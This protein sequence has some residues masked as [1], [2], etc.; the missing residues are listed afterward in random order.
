QKC[1]DVAAN[2]GAAI[3]EKRQAIVDI[4]DE[5]RRSGVKIKNDAIPEGKTLKMRFS[6]ISSDKIDAAVG[7]VRTHDV[8]TVGIRG[9]G[10]K[11]YDITN[12]KLKGILVAFGMGGDSRFFSSYLKSD[13]E[14]FLDIPTLEGKDNSLRRLC[15]ALVEYRIAFDNPSKEQQDID[16]DKLLH[17]A[18]CAYAARIDL[19]LTEAAAKILADNPD[20][21]ND[22]VTAYNANRPTSVNEILRSGTGW[23]SQVTDIV[24]LAMHTV[25]TNRDNGY[26]DASDLSYVASILKK[27]ILLI[28]ADGS[29]L[30]DNGSLEY[31]NGEISGCTLYAPNS[32]P[33]AYTISSTDK[34]RLKNLD[35]IIVIAKGAIHFCGEK[36][37]AQQ[38][39]HTETN[40]NEE[41]KSVDQ[42]VN[43]PIKDQI[44]KNDHKS[45]VRTRSKDKMP[46]LKESLSKIKNSFAFIFEEKSADQIFPEL[47]DRLDEFQN[48][49]LPYLDN[50]KKKWQAD[51]ERENLIHI[52]NCGGYMLK[53]MQFKPKF[54]A[55][56]MLERLNIAMF[57]YGNDE[58]ISVPNEYYKPSCMWDFGEHRAIVTLDENEKGSYAKDGRAQSPG[59]EHGHMANFTGV[60]VHE[61]SG[62][63]VRGNAFS[64]LRDHE[65]EYGGKAEK[66]ENY[67]LMPDGNKASN[68]PERFRRYLLAKA[69]ILHSDDRKIANM[70]GKFSSIFKPLVA[71]Y[72]SGVSLENVVSCAEN[73][74]KKSVNFENFD[75][76]TQLIDL[77]PIVMFIVGMQF[78]QIKGGSW[79]PFVLAA[80]KYFAL[81][82]TK[83]LDKY[84][85]KA[86]TKPSESAKELLSNSFADLIGLINAG[87]Y[88]E[89]IAKQF[90]MA[91][92]AY[93]AIN[94]EILS[95]V[96]FPGN[97]QNTRRIESIFR[98]ESPDALKIM[99]V[100]SKDA[101]DNAK[102]QSASIISCSAA[103]PVRSLDK[104]PKNWAQLIRIITHYDNVHHANVFGNHIFN[105]DFADSSRQ[106]SLRLIVPE[107]QVIKEENVVLKY[108][109]G[110]PFFKDS[111]R[112]LLLLT[113]IQNPTIVGILAFSGTPD[114]CYILSTKK[115]EHANSKAN[116]LLNL[117]D[118]DHKDIEN[119]AKGKGKRKMGISDAEKK[120]MPRE[121]AVRFCLGEKVGKQTD[122]LLDLQNQITAVRNKYNFTEIYT[123]EK[124]GGRK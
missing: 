64:F 19:S 114:E 109:Q 82:S 104:N 93:Y 13:S 28:N 68:M 83:S 5:I 90:E 59:A 67:Y 66:Y 26:M 15:Y 95:R 38:R 80:K 107:E 85:W 111:Q 99:E 106:T 108:E 53:E 88:D 47:K 10:S 32:L 69:R 4:I 27:S 118:I 14:R 122:A 1:T 77:P 42:L 52:A 30:T 45:A 31:E 100:V 71:E 44:K 96:D 43:E 62:R 123:F 105:V 24:R 29:R 58:R 51:A 21:L 81:Q 113:P 61:K 56:I 49:F 22:I 78:G 94:Q 92:C 121:E 120:Q 87:N 101:K 55:K 25:L 65:H 48:K 89:N 11:E 39:L 112:E 12:E 110:C 119:L 73:A 7:Y 75:K 103:G 18:Q 97:T 72:V 116:P 91:L 46:R 50:F 17:A 63:K 57:G 98:L 124:K 34:E 86:Q 102:W 76:N 40:P 33:M 41:I 20:L 16:C 60:K 54:V 79:N 36:S 70:V 9:E 74:L 84:F 37:F 6:K 8:T 35:E 115:D 117:P 2:I 3:A 23:T